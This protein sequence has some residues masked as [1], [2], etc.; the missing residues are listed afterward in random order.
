MKKIFSILMSLVV[1]ITMFGTTGVVVSADY[2]DEIAQLERN[3]QSWYDDI[4]WYEANRDSTSGYESIYFGSVVQYNPLIVH[5]GSKY[6]HIINPSVA[7]QDIT[8]MGYIGF[9]ESLGYSTMSYNGY[10]VWEYKSVIPQTYGKEINALK[11]KIADAEYEIRTLRRNYERDYYIGTRLS[12][13]Y[14]TYSPVD[15][16][17][18]RVGDYKQLEVVVERE[19]YDGYYKDYQN[20][21]DFT[22]SSSN[23][24]VAKVSSDG[25]VTAVKNG[26]AIITAKGVD[27]GRKVT[28]TV[29]V[30]TPAKEITLKK[31]K[32]NIYCGK[33]YTIKYTVSPSTSK[34]PVYFISSDETVVTVSSKGKITTKSPG[35]AYV[36]V[37]TKSGVYK[38]L[39]VNVL[40]KNASKVTHTYYAVKLAKKYHETRVQP[41][42]M[43][44]YFTEKTTTGYKVYAIDFE[45]NIKSFVDY[46]T[47]KANESTRYYSALYTYDKSKKKIVEKTI[48][49][50]TFTGN[51][52]AATEIEIYDNNFYNA[53]RDENQYRYD[54]EP[55]EKVNFV[56]S[57]KDGFLDE[58]AKWT[59][60]N[61]KVA[62]VDKNG[63]VTGLKRGTT[64]ITCTMEG[65]ATASAVV[66]VGI[67]NI[68]DQRSCEMK[69]SEQ[70]ALMVSDN[71]PT[72]TWSTSD[73]SVVTVSPEGV[74]TSEDAILTAV[75]KGEAV[76]TFSFPRNYLY[77]S[78]SI[79][80][81]VTVN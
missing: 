12:S 37:I 3:I 60:S 43:C 34:E 1:M 69:T 40:K 54:I 28:C 80:F 8:A 53:N 41:D 6:I 23:S 36:A 33:T 38:I 48:D 64:T 35:T 16:I 81:H 61:K 56:L 15:A 52:I 79:S 19:N 51:F 71:R 13:Y 59:S 46:L 31:E 65:G 76:I 63:V 25:E 58:N 32:I 72:G 4:A 70:L 55:G 21:E 44:H 49:G 73:P 75:G 39:T 50:H 9:V 74:Y 17:S 22:W 2:Q 66:N 20:S 45:T 47:G 24:K 14:N 57:I 5:T 42:T 18:M 27:S 10:T 77:G 68:Y 26:K 78:T 11:A 29:T 7:Q 62:T 67:I 30:T